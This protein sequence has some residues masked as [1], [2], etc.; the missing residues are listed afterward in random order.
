MTSPLGGE[1]GLQSNPGEEGSTHSSAFSGTI[2][3]HE[4]PPSPDG[5]AADL[6]P[7]GRGIFIATS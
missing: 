4:Q 7:E 6:S 1:V 2:Q 5:F 3:T